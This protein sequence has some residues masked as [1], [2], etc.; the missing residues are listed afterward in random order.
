MT[1]NEFEKKQ[2]R[3]IDHIDRRL[4]E[5]IGN[6]ILRLVFGSKF[7]KTLKSAVKTM[8]ENPEMT[9]AIADFHN[10]VDNILDMEKRFA[11]EDEALA[12]ANR[13]KRKK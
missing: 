5:S 3:Q 4:D 6:A 7:K 13:R 12:K 2:L 1:P 9:A 10:T 8:E 11:K